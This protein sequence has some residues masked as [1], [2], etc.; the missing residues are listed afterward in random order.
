[1]TDA[2]VRLAVPSG[3]EGARLDAFLAGSLEGTSRSAVRRM[4]LEGRVRVEGRPASKPGVVLRAGMALEVSLPPRVDETLRPEDVPLTVAY[5]DEHLLVVD[6]PA[7]LVV[8]PGHGKRSG[9]LVNA[10]LGR[11]TALAPAG[12]TSRPGIV[13]RLDAGT[14][15]LLVV[16]KTD[17]ALR[18]L[19]RAFAERRVRKTRRGSLEPSRSGGGRIRS[20]T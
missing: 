11:G 14:S 1:M 17:P 18:A 8:H 4:I 20:G 13:H 12:G 19:Q 2:V 7:G 5:E 9:T 3:S 10:L 16:A 15:G 6:K